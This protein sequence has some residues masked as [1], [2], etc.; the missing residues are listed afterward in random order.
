MRSCARRIRAW[1]GM[2][3]GT[4]WSYAVSGGEKDGLLGVEWPPGDARPQIS[5]FD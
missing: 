4:N 3:R 1:T 5:H 2:F